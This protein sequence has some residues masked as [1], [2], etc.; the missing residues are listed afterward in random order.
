MSTNYCEQWG[1]M[2]FRKVLEDVNSYMEVNILTLTGH[3]LYDLMKE[4]YDVSKLYMG[5]ANNLTGITELIVNMYFN[6]WVMSHQLPYTLERNF[7]VSGE[8]GKKNEL[9]IALLSDSLDVQYGISIKRDIGSAGW[10]VHEKSSVIYKEML[11]KYKRN[12]NLLQDYWRLENI[13]RG[14]NRHFSTITIIFEAVKEKDINMMKE[15]TDDNP[16]YGYL[17]LKHHYKSL[18]YD[19]KE[20]LQIT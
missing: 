13:K 9:D 20:K 3:D 12:N 7:P 19:L 2:M 11:Q 14:V 18:F 15:I 17:I 1:A 5:H 10:K 8:N 4:F 6:N 16:S